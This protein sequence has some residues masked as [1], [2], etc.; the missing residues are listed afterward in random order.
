L[1]I[2][3]A[4]VTELGREYAITLF[5]VAAR[6]GSERQNLFNEFQKKVLTFATPR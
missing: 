2:S 1:S 5:A 3:L 6:L 4:E